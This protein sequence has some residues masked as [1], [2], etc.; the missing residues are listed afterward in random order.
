MTHEP[1]IWEVVYQ[2]KIQ[3]CLA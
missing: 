2:V 1:G 3:M